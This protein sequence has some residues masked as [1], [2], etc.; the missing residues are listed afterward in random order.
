MYKAFS[1]FLVML[2]ILLSTTC[3]YAQ[4]YNEYRYNVDKQIEKLGYTELRKKLSNE[5]H[6]LEEPWALTYYKECVI[7]KSEAENQGKTYKENCDKWLEEPIDHRYRRLELVVDSIVLELNN[8]KDRF[9]REWFWT[10]DDLAMM[11]LVKMHNE[12]AKFDLKVQTGELKADKGHSACNAMIWSRSI[13]EFSQEDLIGYNENDLEWSLIKS[14]NCVAMSYKHLIFHQYRCLA[15]EQLPAKYKRN[16]SKYKINTYSV[17]RIYRGYGSGY[18]CSPET[19]TKV[20][21]G[22]KVKIK[23]VEPL[24]RARQFWLM[25]ER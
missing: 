17:A 20:V 12:S 24:K 22:E 25:K 5:I 2:G 16:Y 6:N 3:A 23:L 4:S 9:G 8:A 11:S 7:K 19:R 18:S 1:K 13:D 10:K 15:G 21:N 14:R